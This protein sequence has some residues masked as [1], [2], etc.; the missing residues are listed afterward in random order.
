MENNEPT[1]ELNESLESSVL[2]INVLVKEKDGKPA[3][4]LRALT[5]NPDLIKLLIRSAY[6]NIPVIAMPRFFN[7]VRSLSSCIE[8]G[9]LIR[10]EDGRY[11]FTF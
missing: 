11:Y 3:I 9:I 1:P 4:E 7:V 2:V 6:H 5:Q 10:E 8:K